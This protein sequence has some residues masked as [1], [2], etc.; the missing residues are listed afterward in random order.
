MYSL[1]THFLEQTVQTNFFTG[2][3]PAR[4]RL[5][6]SLIRP[7]QLLFRQDFDSR[8][9]LQQVNCAFLPAF[10]IESLSIPK[11]QLNIAAKETAV[12]IFQ[13]MLQR[14]RD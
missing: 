8:V 14:F 2:S 9:L 4:S 13:S 10:S 1:F 3:P 11:T 12:D 7:F 5:D 6:I